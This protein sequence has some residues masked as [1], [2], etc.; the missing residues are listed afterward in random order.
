MSLCFIRYNLW[1]R[2]KNACTDAQNLCPL[3]SRSVRAAGAPCP[4][5]C[6]DWGA[7][8]GSLVCLFAECIH[9]LGSDDLT[10]YLNLVSIIFYYEDS[11]LPFK[12]L[13]CCCEKDRSCSYFTQSEKSAGRWAS[14]CANI[15]CQR[16]QADSK[17]PKHAGRCCSH[18]PM[19]VYIGKRVGIVCVCIVRHES[20]HLSLHAT[21]VF[22]TQIVGVN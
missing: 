8:L 20:R 5:N 22:Y 6:A 1:E 3:H 10:S 16:G 15:Q 17:S 12:Q 21:Y 13:R 14:Q 4:V 7:D 19:C 11:C 9:L 18:T 2:T